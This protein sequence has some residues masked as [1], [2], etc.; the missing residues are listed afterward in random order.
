MFVKLALE[1]KELTENSRLSFNLPQITFFTFFYY[2]E[3]DNSV[4]TY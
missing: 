1:L 2:E 3:C 4:M